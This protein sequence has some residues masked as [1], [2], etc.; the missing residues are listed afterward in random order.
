L[1]L[2]R[3]TPEHPVHAPRCV[4]RP[5]TAEPAVGYVT[6]ECRSADGGEGET[7]AA[8]YGWR[9]QGLL[10]DGS[11]ALYGSGGWPAISVIWRV[12]DHPGLEN[13]AVV[14]DRTASIT[15][16]HGW[17]SVERERHLVTV[18]A[19]REP[20]DAEV[21]HPYLWPA[22]A[23]LSR[24]AGRET[25]HAGAI[26]LPGSPGAW[27]VLGAS[28]DGKSSL[29]ASVAMAGC[30]VAVDDLVVVDGTDC[31]AGPRCIDLKPDAARA[32]DL[33]LGTT[34]VRATS[35]RRLALPPCAGRMRFGASSNSRGPRRSPSAASL[36]AP[37]SPA[38]P[39]TVASPSWGP[40]WISCS[41]S[42]DCRCSASPDLV[43]GRR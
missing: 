14:N 35:R 9:V 42:P 38:W 24:W 37:A 26:V 3:T 30:T 12:A 23:V 15:V 36:P 32:L 22:A 27:V 7:S 43:A 10:T 29:L 5:D 17:L 31:Y 21:I 13:D 19:E 41:T 39:S 1:S 20:E 28:G 16:P 40:R 6:R 18:F 33:E 4:I 2:L 8:A 34:P 25:L 11:L